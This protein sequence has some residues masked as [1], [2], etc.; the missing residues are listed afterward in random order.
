[1]KTGKLSF[2]LG[3][4]AAIIFATSCSDYDNGYTE[5]TI[6]YER[7]FYNAF[8]NIDPKQDWN[9]VKQLREKGT[10]GTNTNSNEWEKD[11]Y[12]VPGDITQEEIDKVLAVF[13]QKGEESY[14]SLVDW[15]EF[16]VQQVW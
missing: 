9:L 14:E 16:F 7:A 12:V 11:G 10:R 8:G 15:S 2:L 3:L 5:K 4:F 6:R 1:M 13:N